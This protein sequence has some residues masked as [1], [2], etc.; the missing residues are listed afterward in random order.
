M[1]T[2]LLCSLYAFLAAWSVRI[3]SQAKD[4]FG[5]VLAIACTAITF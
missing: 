2:I 3:A 1:I 5:A 4:R